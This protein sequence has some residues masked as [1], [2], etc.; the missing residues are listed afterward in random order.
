MHRLPSHCVDVNVHPTKREVHFLYEDVVLY[1]LHEECMKL[2]MNVNESRMFKVQT[3][4]PYPTTT[5]TMSATNTSSM[6]I[7]ATSSSTSME[8]MLGNTL[9]MPSTVSHTDR[10]VEI[11]R[12]SPTKKRNSAMTSQPPV[13]QE[14]WMTNQKMTSSPLRLTVPTT[15][16]TTTQPPL[17]MESFLP[18]VI[19]ET[20]LPMNMMTAEDIEHT[21]RYV[22]AVSSSSSS[23]SSSVIP[24]LSTTTNQAMTSSGKKRKDPSSSSSTI[25]STVPLSANKMVRVD[26]SSSKLPQYF[27]RLPVPHSSAMMM[28]HTSPAPDE[29]VNEEEQEEVEEMS[30]LFCQEIRPNTCP[31]KTRMSSS[32]LQPENVHD[33]DDDNDDE[34]NTVT[35]TAGRHPTDTMQCLCCPPGALRM[36]MPPVDV[37]V[38]AAVTAAERSEEEE[39]ELSS[40][41]TV[42]NSA[43][44]TIPMI[45]HT[46]Q[47]LTELDTDIQQHI[48]EM[49]T[50][51]HQSIHPATASTTTTLCSS[52]IRF[53]L[54][55]HLYDHHHTAL[56]TIWKGSI[57]IGS[58][59]ASYGLFQYQTKLYLFP[60]YPILANFFYQYT[61]LQ[62]PF[63]HILQLSPTLDL[64]TLLQEG[65]MSMQQHSKKTEKS[66]KSQKTEKSQETQKTPE[67]DQVRLLQIANRLL[68]HTE[69]FSALFRIHIHPVTRH[70]E[71]IPDI[72]PGYH[73]SHA[74][75]GS[76]LY[77]LGIYVDWEEDDTDTLCS[78]ETTETTEQQ[79]QPQKKMKKSV[80]QT[81]LMMQ[82]CQVIGYYYA[83][84][85]TEIITHPVGS[86]HTP[87]TTTSATSTSVALTDT[88]KE[89]MAHVLFPLLKRYYL[90][91]SSDTLPVPHTITNHNHMLMEVTSLEQLYKVFERC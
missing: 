91:A 27:Q 79:P 60:Y 82:I 56:S 14:E 59:D 65:Y 86:R 7:P 30:T 4:L 80:D 64:M 6:A 44:P 47:L 87:S 55:Q 45:I 37:N 74:Q 50:T 42:T 67:K 5:T 13:E 32:F 70:L 88:A 84:L 39:E 90:P 34:S 77:L 53:P 78:T 26:G 76:L 57:Y 25:P 89:E 61:L 69:Y 46:P 3:I 11:V 40:P 12:V 81:R 36:H 68:Q 63:F 19:P 54:F 10:G 72:V 85:P 18:A 21:P 8:S 52:T 35:N 41:H 9:P 83:L 75:L 73:P 48:Q 1:R 22:S 71:S 38:V 66:Q 43:Y 58:V 24:H 51:Y 29:A 33:N 2:L 17:F 23:S 49:Y 62:F 20:V 31:K 15:M 28:S 16:T